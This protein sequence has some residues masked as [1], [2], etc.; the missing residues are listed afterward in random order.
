VNNNTKNSRVLVRQSC[1]SH[2]MGVARDFAVVF[3]SYDFLLPT[4]WST[5]LLPV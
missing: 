3:L 2:E 1:Q 4:A 5:L